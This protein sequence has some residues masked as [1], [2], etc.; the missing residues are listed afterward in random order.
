[1]KKIVLLCT[2]ALLPSA[3]FAQST[4]QVTQEQIIITGKNTRKRRRGSSIRK[5][6]NRALC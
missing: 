2:T 3:V 5:A 4:G 1:M 6:S